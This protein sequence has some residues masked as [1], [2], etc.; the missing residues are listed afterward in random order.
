MNCVCGHPEGR[1]LHTNLG[2][3]MRC[4]D[5]VCLAYERATPVPEP[6]DL[7]RDAVMEGIQQWL[8]NS[9][10]GHETGANL[11][12]ILKPLGKEPTPGPEGVGYWIARNA[13]RATALALLEAAG[14]MLPNDQ[15][16]VL[17]K[18]AAE[19]AYD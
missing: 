15:W 17:R 5:C 10:A 1:H 16:E 3:V 13:A 18:V 19:V 14:K 12:I 2:H 9:K 11:C 8:G 6:K 7:Y 4:Y